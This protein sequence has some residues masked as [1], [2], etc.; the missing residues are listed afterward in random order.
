MPKINACK[1]GTPLF[2]RIRYIKYLIK[3]LNDEKN[4]LF[5]KQ[6]LQINCL[7]KKL[8]RQVELIADKYD[9]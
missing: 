4:K 3:G 6:D 2:K 7:R 5:E 8:E 9:K 1:I